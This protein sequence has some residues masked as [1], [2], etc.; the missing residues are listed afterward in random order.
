MQARLARYIHDRTRVLAAMSHDL[1][2]PITRLRLRAELL[3]D[4]ELR[5]QVHAAT[6]RRW[7]RWWAPRWISCAGWRAA[8]ARSRVDI[9]AL[10]ESLQED[11]RETGG[12][13]TIEG[14]VQARYVGR[15]QALKRCLR[16]LVDN[17]V[18]YGKSA[19]I[20]VD[21]APIASRSGCATGPGI[22]EQELER[23]FEPFYRVEASR[24]RDTG[25]TGLGLSIAKS[26][27][28]L[29]AGSL[30]VRNREDGG[31]EAILEL[32]RR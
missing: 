8:S 3:D 30:A 10:L 25:G 29:H 20:A 15:P 6:C 13:V 23:V 21:D 11:A 27:A 26:I 9:M 16:N 7:N 19:M 1:K 14:S 5:D 22:P 31:L 12:E 17:A 28:Q 2:T 32:P 24:S 4:A 18:K